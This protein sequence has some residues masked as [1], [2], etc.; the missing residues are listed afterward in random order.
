M[1]I[2]YLGSEKFELRT[3]QTIVNLSYSVSVDGFKFPGPG[4]YEKGGVSV[5]GIPNGDNTLY[6]LR[7]EDTN[8]CYLGK[9]SSELS[10]GEIKELGNIDI[11][12]LPLGLDSTLPVKKALDLVTKIDPRMVIPMLYDD[13]TEFKKGEGVEDGETE[14]LKIKKSE[15]PEEERKTV[16]LRPRV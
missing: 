16:I 1:Q 4:E 13:L 3:G 11:L 2:K 7:V 12:F 15:L 9:L 10:S 5:V 14:V 6:V 8:L